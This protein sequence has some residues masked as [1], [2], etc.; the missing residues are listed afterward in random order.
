MFVDRVFVQ[1][2]AGKGGNGVVAWR[3]EKFIPKGGPL[4]EME[5][6]VAQL[7]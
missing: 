1:F 5:A 4:G 2:S 3:R 7:F 6:E